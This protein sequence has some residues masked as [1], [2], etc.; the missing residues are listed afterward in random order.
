LLESAANS[1][2]MVLCKID[3]V[4][5]NIELRS[6]EMKDSLRHREKPRSK[7]RRKTLGPAF[8]H[9]LKQRV[10]MPHRRAGEQREESLLMT[11]TKEVG[12][13]MGQNA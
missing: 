3:D 9:D 12:G 1:K 4:M 11:V 10:M 6:R 13:K 5:S 8:I 7:P 2:I